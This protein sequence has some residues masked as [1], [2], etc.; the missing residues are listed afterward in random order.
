M[1]N[2]SFEWDARKD[3]E[4]QGKHGVPFVL[5][6]Q[7]FSDPHRVIAEDTRHGSAK[8]QRYSVW[9]CRGWCTDRSVH[10]SLGRCSDNWP[11]LLA[12]GKGY[13]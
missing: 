1:P 8:E 4:N 3:V 13:L 6:Q 11:W 7:A 12:Q 10:A 5:A 2:P 9:A